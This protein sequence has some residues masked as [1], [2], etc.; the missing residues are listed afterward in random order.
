MAAPASLVE[1]SRSRNRGGVRNLTWT[2]LREYT[3]DQDD[4]NSAENHLW[5]ATWSLHG[6]ILIPIDVRVI[7]DDP[8]NAGNSRINVKLSTDYNPDRYPLG[9]ATV[10]FDSRSKL[11]RIKETSDGKIVESDV[12]DDGY[13]FKVVHG[14]NLIPK[15]FSAVILHTAMAQGDIDWDEFMNFI[16]TTNSNDFVNLPFLFAGSAL[17]ANIRIPKFF[18]M[19]SISTVVPLDIELWYDP[20]HQWSCLSDRFRR[21]LRRQRVL[22]EEDDPLSETRI[23]VDVDDGGQQLDPDLAAVRTIALDVW[24]Q[25]PGGDLD[26][27]LTE[28]KD[29]SEFDALVTWM[30]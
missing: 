9:E 4:A 30:E 22:H 19:R 2:G 1:I 14:D 6:H 15:P 10:S 25:E 26:R 12:D 13:Y 3:V 23:Y 28:Q 29:F 16:G 21:E 11:E 27:V 24:A 17:M 8:V 18:V 7:D 20:T 5:T